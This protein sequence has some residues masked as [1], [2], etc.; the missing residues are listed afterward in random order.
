MYLI[1]EFQETE[2][3]SRAILDLREN[4]MPV[5]DLDVFAEEPVEL[6]RGVLDRPSKMSLAAVLGGA[7]NGLG[8]TAFVYWAQHNY[9]LDTG[10]MPT[11]SFWGSG[12]I[13]F[14]MTMLGAVLATFGY[15]LWESGLLRKRDRS[16][17]VPLVPPGSMCLRVRCVRERSAK[18]MELISRS[19]AFRIE[20]REDA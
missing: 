15:F 19:G 4:G 2:S 5:S 16:A 8:A 14:E 13:T 3:L 12:V 9:V 18:A 6:K 20:R 7:I 1:A 11:F 10:G 17:P